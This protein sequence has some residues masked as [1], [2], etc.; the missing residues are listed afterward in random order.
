MG[1]AYT[2]T[3]GLK[4][5]PAQT[6]AGSAAR[7]HPSGHGPGLVFLGKLLTY[8]N[9]LNPPAGCGTAGQAKHHKGEKKIAPV[10]AT[11][12]DLHLQSLQLV[13]HGLEDPQAAVPELLSGGI[14]PEAC[15]QFGMVLRAAGFEHGDILV[16]EPRVPLPIQRIE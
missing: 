11:S 1:A 2:P 15:Q 6:W 13:D 7:G 16:D 4:I 10:A 8:N 14:Q 12:A 5:A 9:V 3:L